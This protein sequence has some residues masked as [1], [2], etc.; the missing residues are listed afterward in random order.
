MDHSL[1][2]RISPFSIKDLMLAELLCQSGILNDAQVVRATKLAKASGRTIGATLCAMDLL[3]PRELFAARRI[4]HRYLSA[5][6]DVVE[7]LARLTSLIR[8]GKGHTGAQR[9]RKSA[10]AS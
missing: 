5:P 9:I 8:G 4:L 2:L 6:D 1:F 7:T 10:V 3:Y